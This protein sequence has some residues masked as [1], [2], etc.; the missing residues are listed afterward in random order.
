MYYTK[1]KFD[2][3]RTFLEKASQGTFHEDCKEIRRI[4]EDTKV[5]TNRY[6]TFYINKDNTKER[7]F[8]KEV[9]GSFKRCRT[10]NFPKKEIKETTKRIND[11]MQGWTEHIAWIHGFNRGKGVLTNA[12]AHAEGKPQHLV[13]MDL[14][15]AFTQ[16]NFYNLKVFAEKVFLFNSSKAR[17][18]A[19]IMTHKGKMVQ[20]NPLSPV[21][22]N[23]MAIPLDWRLYGLAK[24]K[25]LKY[26]RYA[27]DITISSPVYL[28]NSLINLIQHIIQ[29]ENWVVNSKKTIKRKS[30]MEVTGVYLSNVGKG[31]LG[32]HTR[33]TKLKND[34]R[35]LQ[36]L[37]KLGVYELVRA[38]GKSVSTAMVIAGIYA[39]LYPDYSSIRRKTKGKEKDFGTGRNWKKRKQKRNMQE[40]AVKNETKFLS[41]E[42]RVIAEHRSKRS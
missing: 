19:R 9:A 13:N 40:F 16:I 42:L 12:L 37:S 27:D 29:H 25:S 21:I 22:L 31:E 2:Q 23:I 1:D 34:L 4:I 39:W 8:S 32:L 38:D 7:T 41:T 20:G 33:R 11:I 14:E 10:I 28:S 36:R 18:F 24:K 30:L 5:P 3:V 6:G 35:A 26:T 17:K 15:N